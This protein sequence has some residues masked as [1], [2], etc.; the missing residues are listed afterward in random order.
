M[1][2][3]AFADFH[4]SQDA[5]R[6]A[7]QLVA[8]ER[9]DL[10]IVAGDIANYDLAGAKRVLSDLADAGS[11]VYFVPGNMDDPE[12]ASWNGTENLRNLHGK[13]ESWGDTVM[14]GLGGSPRG[15]F[16]TPFEMAETE[17]A[18][19]LR[20]ELSG[21]RSGVLILVSH[22]PPKNTKV[23]RLATGG[24]AGSSAVRRFVEELHPALVISGHIHEAQGKDA[25]GA[26]VLVNVGPARSGN[27]ARLG[28]GNKTEV[29]FGRF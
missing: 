7:K 25:I 11:P 14:I 1:N 27:Y 6:R 24:H 21:H 13:S 3:I 28:L 16:S 29:V 12:L 22:T 8:Q 4:G 20:S 17:L 15:P 9:P 19:L 26:S 18:E 23:D 10:V 2:I 5:Y